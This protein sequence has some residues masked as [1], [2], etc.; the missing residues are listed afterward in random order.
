MRPF[1]MSVTP[2]QGG[3]RATAYTGGAMN[4]DLFAPLIEAHA[5]AERA[6]GL[7]EPN[8]RVGCVITAADGRTVLG[9]GHT[10]AAGEAHA[11]V[12]ALRDAAARGLDVRGG[13]AHVTL[14]PCSHHGRTAP[15]CDALVAAGIARVMVACGDPN[16]MVNGAGIRRL[17]EA[18]LEVA[19]APAAHALA[20]RELNIGFFS[21]MQRGRPWVRMKMAG[22]LDGRCALPNGQ[23]Q[24]ITGAKARADGHAWRRRAGA[25]LSGIGTV[26]ADNPRLDVREV[27]TARQPVRVVVDARLDTPD[28]ARLFEQPSPL[29]F[30]SANPPPGRA[31]RLQA[32]GAE[33]LDLPG[34]DGR[35]DLDAVLA[36]LSRRGIN[37]L[38]LEAG[39]RLSGAW[40]AQD[41]VDECLVYVAP[42]LIGPGRSLCDMP[43]L[44]ELS[45]ARRFE[46]VEVSPIGPD[47]RLRLRPLGRGLF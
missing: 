23:S 12:M 28:D 9:R 22:S 36:E 11:E 43:E 20:C 27:H 45:Q 26:L 5:L 13:I 38:H 4:A 41:L 1:W 25:V 17:R 37:E 15:C 24:W 8:P 30:C 33:V 2:P 40:M 18:G 21:R 14:E 19:L 47:L 31:A 29:L 44:S 7:T 35:V 42:M 6:V 34:H 10:Q 16:P 32:L 3:N 39:A 46:F